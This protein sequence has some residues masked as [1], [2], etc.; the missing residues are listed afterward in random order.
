MPKGTSQVGRTVASGDTTTAAID[1]R[2]SSLVAIYVPTLDSGTVTIQGSK[3]ATAA[4][5]APLKDT[6]AA[7]IQVAAST[8]GFWI[9]A[10]YLARFMGIPWLRIVCGTAQT[11]AREFVVVTAQG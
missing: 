6:S 1:M 4:N 5:F 10:D 7:T 2:G 3:D 9:D 8:G 11:S